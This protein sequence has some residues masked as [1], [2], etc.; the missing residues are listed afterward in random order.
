MP[1]YGI[2]ISFSDLLDERQLEMFWERE[3]DKPPVREL[4]FATFEE[5]GDGIIRDPASQEAIHPMIQTV[6]RAGIEGEKLKILLQGH[7]LPQWPF[8]ADNTYATCPGRRTP[9]RTRNIPQLAVLLKNILEM[10]GRKCREPADAQNTMV[11][12]LA[13]TFGR[14]LTGKP[15]GSNAWELHKQLRQRGVFVELAART[16]FISATPQGTALAVN[17]NPMAREPG[18]GDLSNIYRGYGSRKPSY[19]R[20]VCKYES[21]QPVVKTWEYTWRGKKI[22]HSSEDPAVKRVL[23]LHNAVEEIYAYINSLTPG[24]NSG[25]YLERAICAYTTLYEVE[26]MS[27]DP[28][29]LYKLLCFLAGVPG[30]TYPLPAD[31]PRPAAPRH[32]VRPSPLCSG[33][34]GGEVRAAPSELYLKPISD[35]GPKR[36]LLEIIGRYT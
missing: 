14:S 35:P 22:E 25:Q 6:R 15:E 3:H 16:E 5:V 26:T 18:R 23:W 9:D 33:M 4:T 20:I 1:T 13:C 17:K 30:A 12:M 36:K 32:Q 21:G 19:T 31:Y 28:E 8:I 11:V 24:D 29:R 27:Y 34:F 7:G 2:L 10:G